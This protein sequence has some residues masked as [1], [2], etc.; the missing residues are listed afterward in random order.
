MDIYHKL[1]LSE[2]PEISTL[3]RQTLFCTC[4]LK[5]ECFA[6]LLFSPETNESDEK[7]LIN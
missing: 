2:K 6:V 7:G 4:L 1:P 5:Q 3:L